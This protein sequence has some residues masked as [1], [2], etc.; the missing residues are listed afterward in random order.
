MQPAGHHLALFAHLCCRPEE[1]LDL[2]SAALCIAEPEYP[3]LDIARYLLALDELAERLRPAIFNPA[4]DQPGAEA[5]GSGQGQGQGQSTTGR[6]DPARRGLLVVQALLGRGGFRGNTE[7]YDDP[8]NS[9]LNEVIDRRLGIPITLSVMAM[10]VGRRLGVPLFGVSFPGHFLLRTAAPEPREAGQPEPSTERPE[11]R[12][13]RS[14]LLIDPFEGRAL[15]ALDLKGL[16]HR[17]VGERR[18]A[19][20]DELRT[21]SKHSILLRML[22]NLRNIYLRSSDGPRLQLCVERIRLLEAAARARSERGPLSSPSV[23]N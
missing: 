20:A 16:L 21:A 9:F 22:N 8:R 2:A 6:T 12:T 19:T 5:A 4:G 10:E 14:P 23:P 15:S 13:S 18:E 17:L 1:E 11:L 3:D 7:A